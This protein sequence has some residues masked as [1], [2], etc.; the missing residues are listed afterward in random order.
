M[1]LWR[2]IKWKESSFYTN[3]GKYAD[4]V[5]TNGC[6]DL[7]HFLYSETR[8]LQDLP[9]LSYCGIAGDLNT[10]QTGESWTT[11]QSYHI[12]DFLALML[13]ILSF[14]PCAPLKRIMAV[15]CAM[16]VHYA[17]LEAIRSTSQYVPGCMGTEKFSDNTSDHTGQ[18]DIICCP[19]TAGD[20]KQEGRKSLLLRSTPI[21]EVVAKMIR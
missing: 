2:T 6:M 10:T 15:V 12:P 16:L 20:I 4:L 7:F 17:V 14:P 1:R 19:Y 18:P 13:I 21:H 5:R 3:S 8:S 9:Q 11:S